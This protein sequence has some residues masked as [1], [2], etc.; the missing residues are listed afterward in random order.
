MKYKIVKN[1]KDSQGKVWKK[2]M[3]FEW[4]KME[5]CYITKQ[6][7]WFLTPLIERRQLNTLLKMGLLKRIKD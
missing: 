3:I 1:F 2:N 7:P 5:N 6:L 4:D